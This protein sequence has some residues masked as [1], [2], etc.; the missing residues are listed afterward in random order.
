MS[1]RIF[2]ADIIIVRSLSVLTLGG[3]KASSDSSS[4]KKQKYCVFNFKTFTW[5]G[6]GL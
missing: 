3:L 2:Y 5:T 4:Y 6:S 1:P